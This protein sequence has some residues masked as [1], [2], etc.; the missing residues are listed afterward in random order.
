MG[1]TKFLNRKWFTFFILIGLAEPYKWYLK[2]KYKKQT[3]KI[4][5]IISTRNDLFLT[6]IINY[7]RV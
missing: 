3:I 1:N 2:S 5:K 4:K 6:R 7:I